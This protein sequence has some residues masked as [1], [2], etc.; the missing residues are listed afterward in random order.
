MSFVG[1]K[2]QLIH[3]QLIT[4]HLLS[5]FLCFVLPYAMFCFPFRGKNQ[6]STNTIGIPVRDAE[7]KIECYPTLMLDLPTQSLRL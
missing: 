5:I 3:F 4:C 6:H 7:R 1:S 2:N